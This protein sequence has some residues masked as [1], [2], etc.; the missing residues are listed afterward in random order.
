VAGV[1]GRDARLKAPRRRGR[2]QR[3]ADGVIELAQLE[4]GVGG[5][6]HWRA[7]ALHVHDWREVAP[8]LPRHTAK[9]LP[10]VSLAQRRRR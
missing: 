2:D 7:R 8:R 1:V 10:V 6:F 4:Q 5:R 3:G 9:S